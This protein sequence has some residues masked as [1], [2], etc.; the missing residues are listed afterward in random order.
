MLAMTFIIV[1]ITE[2]KKKRTKGST[3]CRCRD[4]DTQIPPHITS[5]SFHKALVL[6]L[7]QQCRQRAGLNG[8]SVIYVY[9]L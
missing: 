9:Q 4:R 5:T 8:Y 7:A 3:A 6:L 2:K 1:S